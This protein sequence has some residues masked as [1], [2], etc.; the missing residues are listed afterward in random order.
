V[1]QG[2]V[3]RHRLF[4]KAQWQHKNIKNAPRTHN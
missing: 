3:T 1:L 4:T 2:V